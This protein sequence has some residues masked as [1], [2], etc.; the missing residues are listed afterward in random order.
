MSESALN[1]SKARYIAYLIIQKKHNSHLGISREK[2]VREYG[3]MWRDVLFWMDRMER[4][5]DT[6]Q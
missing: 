3:Y 5:W 6:K 2:A 1:N 4:E